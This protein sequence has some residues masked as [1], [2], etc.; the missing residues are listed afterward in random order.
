MLS[1]FIASVF[2]VFANIPTFDKV[3]EV[4]YIGIENS[5]NIQLNNCNP[6]EIQ[7]KVNVG[8]LQKIR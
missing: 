8:S 7:L 3:G 1:T 5:I 2:I 4:V 6:E